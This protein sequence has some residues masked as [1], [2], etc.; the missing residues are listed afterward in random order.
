VVEQILKRLSYLE[1]SKQTWEVHWQEIL[2]YVM[3]RKAEV[4]AQY[5]KGS[6]RTEKLYDSSAIHANTLLA[7]SLQGTL[8]SASLPWFHLRVRDEN[9]NQS[10]ETQVWLEDCRNRMYKAFNSSKQKYM[11]SILIFV[12][13]VQL[14]LRQKKLQMDSTS[15]HFIFQ[16]TLSLKTIKDRLIPYIGSFNI[17]LD[18]LFKSGVM[19]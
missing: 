7:A 4:T 6:K 9:L 1:S 5:A 19:L 17:P 2:D 16:N 14:V 12:L 18:K 8:T 10:R 13:L 3:P 11:S 15:E